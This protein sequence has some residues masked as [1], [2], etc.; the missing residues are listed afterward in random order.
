MLL[1]GCATTAHLARPRSERR[2]GQR[3]L[4]YLECICTSAK[5]PALGCPPVDDLPDVL[6]VGRLAVQILPGKGS[7][8]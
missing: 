3:S 7:D 1:D 6:H 8:T 2:A 5:E 4:Q